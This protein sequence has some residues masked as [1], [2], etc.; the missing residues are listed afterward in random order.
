[1][2]RDRG[3]RAGQA[4]PF[5]GTASSLA[6]VEWARFAAGIPHYVLTNTLTRA[7]WTR[8]RFLSDLNEVAA[9]KQEPGKDIYLIGGAR[10]TTSLIDAGACR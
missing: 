3:G 8:T 10:T 2:E 4:L 9:L 7:N 6:E 1:L 5:T